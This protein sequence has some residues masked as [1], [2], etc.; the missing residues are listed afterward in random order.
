MSTEA[1]TKVTVIVDGGAAG[2]SDC[3]ARLRAMPGLGQVLDSGREGDI[4][5]RWN[6]AAKEAKGEYLLFLKPW[7]NLD[8]EAIRGL[9]NHL[10]LLMEIG[11]VSPT[12]FTSAGEQA[13]QEFILLEDQLKRRPIEI[14]LRP[15]K[16]EYKPDWPSEPM[17]GIAY[18][19]DALMVRKTAFWGAGGWDGKLESTC[20][21]LTLGLALKELGWRV[22]TDWRI[23]VQT[24]C[25]SAQDISITAQESQELVARWYGRFLP[26]G[27]RTTDG[28]IRH[29][30]WIPIHI[31][32]ALAYAQAIASP[33]T[34]KPE[35]V[36]HRPGEIPGERCSVIVVTYNSMETI[37]ACV[38]SSLATLG[39]FDELI[40][41]DNGSRDGTPAYLAG[42]ESIDSRIKV[43][44]NGTNL[45]FSEGCNVGIRASC[46]EYV[47]LLNP[48]TVVTEGWL[49]RMRERFQ[50]PTVGAVGP[51]SNGA[52]GLQSYS[53]HLPRNA[54]SGLTPAELH[55]LAVKVNGRRSVESKLLI[56]FCLMVPRKVLEE[57][58][59]LDPE[60]F[61]GSDDLDLCW[62]LRLAGYRLLIASDVFVLHKVHVSFMTEPDSVT[63]PLEKRSANAFARKLLAHYGRGNVPSQVE[64]WGIDWF[65]PEIEVWKS[66]A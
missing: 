6:R 52:Y 27:L 55:D 25:P 49:G 57:V 23:T 17:N 28:I 60:L 10:D 42:L 13:P 65:V 34:Q 66:A 26:H 39:T 12:Y 56:G 37:A 50:D 30:P 43:V 20:H 38:N 9:A 16:Q 31:G 18:L 22:V 21:G 29:H 14:L 33:L 40:L 11:A 44:L 4:G 58:G 61:L 51:I 24:S 1:L 41:V 5:E 59:G 3:L 45:G 36:A 8:A 64:L 32:S 15:V 47:V 53:F 48:D 54:K 19:A 35:P 63:K 62:R 46:G 2:A 7:I